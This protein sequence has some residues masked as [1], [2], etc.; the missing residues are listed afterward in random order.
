MPSKTTLV[1]TARS[2]AGSYVGVVNGKV[3]DWE[4]LKAIYDMA[5]VTPPNW[6]AKGK[7]GT[8]LQALQDGKWIRKDKEPGGTMDSSQ[9][10]AWCGIFATY[11]LQCIGVPVKWKVG[12]GIDPLSPNLELCTYSKANEIEPGDICVKG[13]NQHHFIVYDH[14][15][16]TLKSYDGNLPGQSIG[17]RTYNI[18]ELKAAAMKADQEMAGKRKQMTDAEFR[19]YVAST[20]KYNFYFYRLK[21]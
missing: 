18:S 16:D 19:K 9:G 14:T 12:A 7:D 2:I 21:V 17:E 1:I 5:M 8:N 15:G 3:R 4:T 6:E 13:A 20:P 11:C 10:I